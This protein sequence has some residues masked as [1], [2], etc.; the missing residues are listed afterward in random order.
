VRVTL[1][2][3]LSSRIDRALVE[4]RLLARVLGVL[5]LMAA[6]L[7]AAGLYGVLAYSTA[8]RTPEIGVRLALGATR[9]GVVWPVLAEAGTLAACGV[10]IGVPSALVLTKLLSNVLYGV[11]PTDPGVLATVDASLFCIAL[12]AASV[13]AWRASRVD[14]LVALRYE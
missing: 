12:L 8:R 2:Q 1:P 10:F 14:P 9:A 11:T 3:T 4:E 5:A 13:P 7:A 6:A